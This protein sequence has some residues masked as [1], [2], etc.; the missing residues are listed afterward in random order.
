MSFSIALK[1]S[2]LARTYTL[3]N[4]EFFKQNMKRYG[5]K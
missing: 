2:W 5:R 4:N 3:A 1:L